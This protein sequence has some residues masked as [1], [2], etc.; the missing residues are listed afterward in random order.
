MHQGTHGCRSSHIRI[1]LNCHQH[2]LPCLRQTYL[3]LLEIEK[4]RTELHSYHYQEQYLCLTNKLNFKHIRYCPRIDCN[5]ILFAIIGRQDSHPKSS[6]KDGLSQVSWVDWVANTDPSS[7][8]NDT[9]AWES[10]Q[11]QFSGSVTSLYQ[12]AIKYLDRINFKRL[13]PT[14][15]PPWTARLSMRKR[16]RCAISC[17]WCLEL[18]IAIVS[19]SLYQHHQ[20]K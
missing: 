1:I 15:F 3:C 7:S 19:L 10:W 8:S 12:S 11:R 4:W 13:A 20:L 17:I 9:V 14:H 2:Q 18:C 6:F 5:L 16:D